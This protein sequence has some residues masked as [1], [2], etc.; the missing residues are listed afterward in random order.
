MLGWFKYSTICDLCKVSTLS[1]IDIVHLTE[2]Q[3]GG[4]PGGHSPTVG[5][6]PAQARL[7]VLVLLQVALEHAVLH[8]RVLRV[9]LLRGPASIPGPGGTS[10]LPTLI[11]NILTWEVSAVQINMIFNSS[12]LQHPGHSDQSS[13]CAQTHTGSLEVPPPLLR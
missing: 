12:Y 11:P 6:P 5:V 10:H 2:S 3:Y 7:P 1:F 13:R 4:A 8:Q 9:R